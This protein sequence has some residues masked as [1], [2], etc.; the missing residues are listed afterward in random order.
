MRNTGPQVDGTVP[1]TIIERGK[2]RDLQSGWQDT[3]RKIIDFR[4][5]NNVTIKRFLRLCGLSPNESYYEELCAS[6]GNCTHP[7]NKP[8]SAGHMCL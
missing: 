8:G 1:A 4:T 5:S 6:T 2:I 7:S 3:H